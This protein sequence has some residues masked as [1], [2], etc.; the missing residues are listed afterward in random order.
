[1]AARD[2]W[3]RCPCL[4]VVAYTRQSSALRGAASHGSRWVL[5][6]PAPAAG[7]VRALSSLAP[8]PPTPSLS[9]VVGLPS[10][11]PTPGR[12]VNGYSHRK[13]CC[14]P[15]LR[16]FPPVATRRTTPIHLAAY[17]RGSTEITNVSY[18]KNAATIA[19][20][21]SGTRGYA[22]CL[23]SLAARPDPES[24]SPISTP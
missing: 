3:Q 20:H 16:P 21:C 6:L 19:P 12:E 2:S 10:Q 18:C 8:D 22:I 11:F 4:H 5:L 24:A 9:L 17:F 23:D 14:C 13:F 15:P 7:V 1:M